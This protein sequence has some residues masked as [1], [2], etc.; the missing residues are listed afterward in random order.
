[1]DLPKYGPLIYVMYSAEYPRCSSNDS[2]C[3]AQTSGTLRSHG[4]RFM[5]DVVYAFKP[6]QDAIVSISLC[7]SSFDTTL[8]LYSRSNDWAAPVEAAC[9]D[10]YCG[11]QSTQSYLQ[12]HPTNFGSAD[13]AL[14]DAPTQL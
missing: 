4:F 2:L 3:H 10:D 5:Q 9:N 14:Q 8:A 7:G 11:P 13:W 6:A 12:V 1:M